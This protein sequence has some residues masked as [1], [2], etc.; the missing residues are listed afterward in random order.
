[1]ASSTSLWVHCN[2]YMKLVGQCPSLHITSCGRVVCSSCL[3]AL[4]T[5]RCRD[6][7]GPCSRTI[8]LDSRAPRSVQALFKNANDEL[9]TTFKNLKWQEE[10]KASIMAHREKVVLKQVEEARRQQ[11][12]LERLDAQLKQKKK[13]LRDMGIL[14]ER[15]EIN[16]MQDMEVEKKRMEEM[17]EF[18]RQAHK[19]ELSSL[20]Q[21]AEREKQHLDEK[22]NAGEEEREKMA[23]EHAEEV[24]ML[25]VQLAVASRASSQA[26]PLFSEIYKKKMV[27]MKQH[28]E[29]Q[30]TALTEELARARGDGREPGTGS[31]QPGAKRKKVSAA[32]C[33]RQPTPS[34][35]S[36]SGGRTPPAGTSPAGTPLAGTPLA[37]T[38]PR[39][40]SP[41]QRG[42]AGSSPTATCPSATGQTLFICPM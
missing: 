25:K 28:Y 38:S 3:P 27:A 30:L 8:P 17:E 20:G 9:K 37:G 22:I 11:Q 31:G 26:Q 12:E 36:G 15:I 40:S 23:V 34:L 6:C 32:S 7:R 24:E 2:L 18:F 16:R 19:A 4:R 33:C 13:H 10:Q 42:A 21:R 41:S 29:R 14:Q 1:M 35:P 5:A 39:C